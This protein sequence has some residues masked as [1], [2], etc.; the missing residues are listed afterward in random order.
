MTGYAEPTSDPAELWGRGEYATIGAKLQVVADRL[1][2]VLEPGAGDRVLDLACGN[3][4][5]AM[6]AAKR[7]AQVMALDLAPELLAQARQRAEAEGLEV[8]FVEGNA[9]SLPFAETRFDVVV[10]TFG[11]MFAPDHAR[12]AAEMV[13]VCKPGGRIAM[14]NW[15]PAGV[16]GESAA[17]MADFLPVAPDAPSPARWG[18]PDYLAG[19]FSERVRFALEPR[20]VMYRYPDVDTYLSTLIETY[21]PLINSF[22]RL[23]PV[24]RPRLRARLRELYAS[25]NIA[26][27]GSFCMPMTYLEACGVRIAAPG[28]A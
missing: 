20:K 27:D 16:F 22:A 18:D 12:A 19:L 28:R 4:N 8:D 13:R 9:L 25:R 26:E 1:M 2:D 14:A 17:V 24:D 15:S 21:P 23:A 7:G 10:S 11:V 5:A 6:A 3:G